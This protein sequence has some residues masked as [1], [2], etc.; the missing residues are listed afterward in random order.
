MDKRS[1]VHLFWNYFK[2]NVLILK[3]TWKV[4]VYQIPNIAGHFF[5]CTC[6]CYKCVYELRCIFVPVCAH[7]QV[8]MCAY[9]S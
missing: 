4:Q 9:G 7:V 2:I 8:F 6:V 3:Y 5:V 1:H